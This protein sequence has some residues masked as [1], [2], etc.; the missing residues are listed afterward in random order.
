MEVKLQADIF[1]SVLPC[2]LPYTQSRTFAEHALTPL[3][4]PLAAVL[5]EVDRHT[6]VVTCRLLHASPPNVAPGARG[7][8]AEVAGVV[9]TH[10]PRRPA[11]A[12][13]TLVE[14]LRWQPY[15]VRLDGDAQRLRY[16]PAWS[17]FQ[18]FLSSASGWPMRDLLANHAQSA[19]MY[20]A[21][22]ASLIPRWGAP[23]ACMLPQ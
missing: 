22:L 1:Y 5:V 23:Y 11:A 9:M 18:T 10:A 17:L 2:T 21:P 8:L 13:T 6:D 3:L 14:L 4:R 7:L 15:G 16:V 19:S 12:R 20:G